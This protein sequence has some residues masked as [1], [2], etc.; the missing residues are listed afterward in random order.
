MQRTLTA[1][2]GEESAKVLDT[3]LGHVADQQAPN[4]GDEG[5]ESD[6]VGTQSKLVGEEGDDEGVDSTGDVRRGGQEKREL[7][8]VSLSTENDGQE[9]GEGV[10]L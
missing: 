10:T 7:V 9:V 3:V 4:D 1:H 6:E 8:R 5:I 2:D